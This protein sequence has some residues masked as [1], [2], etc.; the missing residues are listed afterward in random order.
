MRETQSTDISKW[1]ARI[2]MSTHDRA[3][4]R[5]VRSKLM[6][7]YRNRFW[8][9]SSTGPTGNA[10]GAKD[11]MDET[12]PGRRQVNYTSMLARTLQANLYAQDPTFSC[13]SPW[14]PGPTAPRISDI[15]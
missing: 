9:N 14:N 11:A 1:M 10:G 3:R 12:D 2:A 6:R 8:N 7:W 15:R 13:R 4:D 5:E